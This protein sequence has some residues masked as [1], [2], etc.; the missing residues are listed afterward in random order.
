MKLVEL[1]SS[2]KE[3]YNRFVA[4]QQAGSFLQAW[5]W[6]E[7]QVRL[8]RTVSRFKISDDSG[9]QAGSIQLIKMPLPFGKYYLYAPYGPVVS[10]QWAVGSG[11]LLDQLKQKFPEAIFIRLEPKTSFLSTTHYPVLTKSANIQPTKTLVLDLAKT[12]EQ[13]LA[14]MHPKTRYNIKLAQRHNVEVS[15]DLMVVPGYGLYLKEALDLLVQTAGRQSF[16]TFPRSY[17]EQLLNFFALHNSNGDV[18]L[19]VYK[20]LKDKE[21]LVTA[22]MVDFGGTRTYLFGGS[23]PHHR[24]VMAP[25][26]LHWQAILDAKNLGLKLYDFWGI[27]TS[28]G[29]TPGFVRFKMG[30]GGEELVYAGAY[31]IS[32]KK[33]WYHGY[34]GLRGIN[35]SLLHIKNFTSKTY[36]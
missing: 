13:L 8:G 28:S 35:R 2:D 33:L 24:E 5:E 4:S 26:A 30:F 11:Q 12:E 36:K 25:Y 1:T 19:Y 14:E 10:G 3:Q 17:Y 20:A 29:D 15:C 7:W 23:S 31:D 27:E 34:K 32:N 16:Q 22:V 21:L 18:K 6:G 9:N